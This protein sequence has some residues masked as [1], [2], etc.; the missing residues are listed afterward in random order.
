MKILIH[1]LCS[2]F[3]EI[4]CL[5]VGEKM[6]HFGDKSSQNAVFRRH[7]AP[8]WWRASSVWSGSWDSAR[9]GC[10]SPQPKSSVQPTSIKFT[11]VLQ[12]TYLSILVFTSR[13][14]SS[15][16]IHTPPLFQMELEK[17]VGS[18]WTC[19]GVRVPMNIGLSNR[20]LKSALKCTVWPQCTPVPDGQTDEH[21]GNSATIRSTNASRAKNR[22]TC[23]GDSCS[24]MRRK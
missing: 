14:R 16:R 2:N 19:F 8:V 13:P 21:H 11:Y 3:T 10:R 15:L 7:F 22:F 1:A 9:C 20:K 12:S 6:L 18:R 4:S 5:E 23:S 24:Y 17:T